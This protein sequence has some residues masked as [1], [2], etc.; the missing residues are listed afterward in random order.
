MALGQNENPALAEPARV[1]TPPELEGIVPIRNSG[2]KCKILMRA[3]MKSLW[4]AY[5]FLT[6]EE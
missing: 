3:F 1:E 6:C 2:G 5:A 4:I